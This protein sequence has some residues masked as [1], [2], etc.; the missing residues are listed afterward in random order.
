MFGEADLADE[1][2][3]A[4]EEA[5]RLSGGL[6]DGTV[7]AEDFEAQ[8]G[9]TLDTANAALAE[10]Q[11]IDGATFAGVTSALGGLIVRLGEAAAR[12]AQLRSLLP[13]ASAAAGAGSGSG[14]GGDPRAQGGSFGDWATATG[15]D[16]APVSTSRPRPAPNDPDFGAPV[17]APPMRPMPAPRD[18]DFGLPP[19]RSGGG[20]GGRGSSS[21][22]GRGGG[23]GGSSRPSD[24]QREAERIRETTRELELEAVALA[25][26]S[27]AHGDM[28]SAIEDARMSAD[29]LGAAMKSGR[30]D[31]AALRAEI[32]ATVQAHRQ[33]ADAAS[34]VKDRLDRISDAR[35]TLEGSAE[36]AFLG[37]VKGTLSW[38]DALGQVLDTLLEIAAKAAF[39]KFVAPALGGLLGPLGGLLGFASGGFTGRGATHDPAGIVH[40]GEFVFSKRATEALGVGNLDALHAAAKRGYA[41]GGLVGA[42]PGRIGPQRAAT[43]AVQ[44]IEINAPVTVNGS[45]GSPEQNADLAKRMAREMDATMRGVVVSEL[46]KQMRPGAMLNSGGR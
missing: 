32:A 11:A 10:L 33:A 36:G 14:R 37:L 12:A 44:H 19:A 2:V 24:Y 31:N 1:L 7:S 13:G 3:A 30:T 28:A 25:A 8:L 43:G 18:V 42:A 22:A 34:Q 39:Q 16:N 20:G 21:R 17:A 6:A 5:Y 40:R 26:V 46:A 41:A 9:V 45:A 4:A 27:V 15:T 23:G 35:R 29:L 38:R